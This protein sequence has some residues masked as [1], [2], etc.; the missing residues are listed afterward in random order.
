MNKYKLVSHKFVLLA[1]L[2]VQGSKH[3]TFHV[4]KAGYYMEEYLC[5]SF[6]EDTLLKIHCFIL[7][8]PIFY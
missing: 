2:M 1:V 6:N 8:V 5:I 3:V 7:K 4:D